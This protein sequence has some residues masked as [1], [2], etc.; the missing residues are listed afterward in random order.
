MT[1]IYILNTDY[2]I[3]GIVDNYS[4]AIFTKRYWKYGDFEL[5]I[6]A[7][8]KSLEMLQPDFYVQRDGDSYI[9]VIE[10]IQLET[11]PEDGD[12]LAVK[13]RSVESML[14]RRILFNHRNENYS[15]P[16]TIGGFNVEYPTDTHKTVEDCVFTTLWR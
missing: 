9:Y 14:T 11:N 16:Y 4:S 8:K 1:D 2:Q 12:F 10:S 5:Y 15:Q 13:G 6:K 3:I 7:N